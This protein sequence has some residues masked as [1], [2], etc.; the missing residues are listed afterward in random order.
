[1]LNVDGVLLEWGS[2][3]EGVEGLMED[4][5][6]V[7]VD[8]RRRGERNGAFRGVRRRRL[9]SRSNIV[10]GRVREHTQVICRKLREMRKAK[11]KL[12][13]SS[14]PEILWRR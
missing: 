8:G 1:V 4:V 10:D 13:D 2:K 7:G 3:L 14:R 9:G 6:V 5:E 11:D 12:N